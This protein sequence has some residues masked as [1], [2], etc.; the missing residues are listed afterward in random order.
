[1]SIRLRVVL[2]TLVLSTL[3]VS[4]VDITTFQLLER[5]FNTRADTSVRQVARAAEIALGQGTRLTLSAFAATD[6]PVLVEVVDRRGHVVQ[7]LTTTNA[8][9][10]HLPA[11]LRRRQGHAEQIDSPDHPGPAFEAIALPVR[12][13]TLIVVVSTREGVDTLTHL[14]RLNV[15]VGGVVL[16][17]FVVVAGAVLTRSLRPLRRIAATADAIA[18]GDLAARVPAPPRRSE[19]TSVATALN[20]MLAENEV[21][22]AE[23]DATEDKLR[24]FL[25]DASHELRTPLTSIRGYAELFRRGAGERPEDLAQV[26]RAIEDEAT[27]M[28][29]LVDDLL[30]LAQLDE[31]RPHAWGPVAL[32]A[33]VE[34][35]VG[36]ARAIEPFRPIHFE[37]A[38]RPLLVRGDEDRLRQVLDNLLANVRQHTPQ[39]AGVFIGLHA[40]GNEALLVVEDAGPGVPDAERERIFDRFS[41]P[42]AQRAR[43]RDRGG[44]GLG[45]AIVRSIVTAHGGQITVRAAASGH[46]AAFHVQLPRLDTALG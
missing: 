44:A 25:A 35:A 5:Y 28:T 6:R 9:D 43:A 1:V 16:V 31:G 37:L 23:R 20:R 19:I 24:R 30:L 15:I 45:L 46:G 10:V 38:E 32:D 29:V 22:F 33:V 18:A 7:R 26:M 40:E 13:G 2:T 8:G 11:D 41:R 36:A 42:D 27:R 12:G 4:A 3:A 14:V 39:G 21:A 34:A 17:I